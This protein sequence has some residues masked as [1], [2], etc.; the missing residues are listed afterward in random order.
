MYTQI[1]KKYYK[2]CSRYRHV[3]GCKSQIWLDCVTFFLYFLRISKLI[4]CET[5]EHEML[6]HM[7]YKG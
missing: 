2:I 3:S 5:S 7:I 6:S 4:S 1:R